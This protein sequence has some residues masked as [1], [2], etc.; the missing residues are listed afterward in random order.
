VLGH[1]FVEEGYSTTVRAD[2]MEHVMRF[3]EPKAELNVVLAAYVSEFV[4]KLMDVHYYEVSKYLLGSPQ[5]LNWLVQ[6][7]YDASVCKSIL[8]PLIFKPERDIDLETSVL[9][10]K[11]ERE[12]IDKT[13]HPLRVKL[14]KDVWARVLS[15]QDAE[16]TTNVLQMFR[17]AVRR[18]SGEER[19]KSFL[20]ETLYSQQTVDG[21]F[22]FLL[23]TDVS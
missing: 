1:L 8:M 21:L 15:S 23:N 9:E 17:D 14:L 11:L 19:F 6:H 20:H 7:M 4:G 18:S 3:F 2:R 22:K 12:Q 5:K 10:K 16:L 13:L